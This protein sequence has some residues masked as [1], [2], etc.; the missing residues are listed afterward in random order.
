MTLAF[1][2][3]DLGFLAW[4]ALAPFFY[5]VQA[6]RRP[7]HAFALGYLFGYTHWGATVIWIGTTVTGWTHSPIG[8]VAWIGLVAVKSLWFGAFGWGAWWLSRKA[9]GAGRI[10]AIAGAWTLMEWLRCQT[11]VAMPWSLSGYTQY[12][13]L[14]LIQVA[15]IGGVFAVAFGIAL[16]NAGLADGWRERSLSRWRLVAPGVVYAVVMLVYGAWALG[17]DY[18]GQPFRL[19]LMQPNERSVREEQPKTAEEEIREAVPRL[20]QLSARAASSHP[21]LVVWPES[22][23]PAS[24]LADGLMRQAVSDAARRTHAWTLLGSPHEDEKGNG[25]NS[26]FLFTPD[27]TFADRYDKTWLVPFGEWVPLRSVLPF[28]SLFHFPKETTPGAVGALVNAG[29]ARM[30]VL[31]CYELV[32][33]IISRTRTAGGANLLVSITN[34]SWAGNS[35]ELQQHIAMAAFRAVET[36]RYLALSATTGITAL[37]SPTGSMKSIPSYREDLLVADAR[38]RT[39]RTPY[40]R[41][42]DWLV[43]LCGLWVL[44]I[45]V[46]RAEGRNTSRLR[47]RSP[48]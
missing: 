2:P 19:A 45:A 12:R 47:G 20:A 42:G 16:M 5:A 35:A 9:P 14:P 8:W 40:V 41:W 18:A 21:D 36:R 48:I 38:L 17:H 43:G 15:E 13:Y 46:R 28:D 32:F 39:G 1:P 11:G 4:V 23:I 22:A 10:A 3:A 6:A 31:I 24:P 27:G 25:Y 26:A 29:P 7:R 44:I 34:D 33:P 37:I 30:S